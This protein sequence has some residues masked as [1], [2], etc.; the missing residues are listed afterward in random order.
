MEHLVKGHLSISEFSSC[1]T[2]S[3]VSW[4]N[5][6]SVVSPHSWAWADLMTISKRTSVSVEISFIQITSNNSAAQSKCLLLFSALPLWFPFSCYL[7]VTSL[8]SKRGTR[9]SNLHRPLLGNSRMC[10]C[11]SNLTVGCSDCR[12]HFV[13]IR[14]SHNSLCFKCPVKSQYQGL[15]D[16]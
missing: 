3:I 16:N 1:H 9:Q 4:Q 7:C 12:F 15:V 8:V 14:V 5:V 11:F 10:I 13:S 2:V 6:D